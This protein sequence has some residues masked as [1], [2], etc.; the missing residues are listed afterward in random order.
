[1]IFKHMDRIVFA[2]DSVTDMESAQPVGEGL[3]ENVGKSY[4]RIVEN[5]LA[6]FYP[7]VYHSR[8]KLRYQRKHKPRSAAAV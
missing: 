6:A 2:G 1:M 4:V 7:E 3:F 8:D 5:M